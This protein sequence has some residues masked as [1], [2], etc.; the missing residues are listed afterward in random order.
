MWKKAKVLEAFDNCKDPVLRE[1][2]AFPYAQLRYSVS[3]ADIRRW[4]EVMLR[5]LKLPLYDPKYYMEKIIDLGV[6]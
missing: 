3:H 6:L 1:R 2:A 5:R 4:S